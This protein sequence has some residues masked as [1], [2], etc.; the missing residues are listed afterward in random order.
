MD[1][2]TTTTTDTLVPTDADK[3]PITWLGNNAHI[4]GVLYEVKRWVTR[5]G[6][7][8]ALIQHGA[9]QLSNGKLAIDSVN[10]FKFV[11]GKVSDPRTFDNPC[12]DT[13]TR[14]R[15]YNR[16][17]Q[18]PPAGAA[19]PVPTPVDDGDEE[20]DRQPVQAPITPIG[21]PGL[22]QDSIPDE[23]K[24]QFI[25]S[26]Y[27]VAN[28][29]ARLLRSLSHVIGD[30]D[31][32]DTLLDEAE[33][34]GRA[35]IRALTARAKKADGRDRALIRTIFDKVVARGVQGELTLD[36]LKTFLKSY[37]AARRHLMYCTAPSIYLVSIYVVSTY[38]YRSYRMV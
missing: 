13:V 23:Y 38:G 37:Q 2:T 4:P 6:H 7:F 32:A 28:E 25:V 19:T 9:V 10:S 29:D 26:E 24:Y 20:S 1:T 18:R 34:S 14:E 11:I 35:L 22:V 8:K 16:R 12:P 5:T 27:A 15:E 36:S 30:A 3:E 17:T 21:M 33:G 31:C